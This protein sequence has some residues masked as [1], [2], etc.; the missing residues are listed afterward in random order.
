M[1]DCKIPDCHYTGSELDLALKLTI[2]IL[3]L[4]SFGMSIS[5]PTGPVIWTSAPGFRSPALSPQGQIFRSSNM[6]D[7][8]VEIRINVNQEGIWT[9]VA[10]SFTLNTS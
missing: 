10:D 5:L 3:A 2:I 4:G 8:Y 9:L 6:S 1:N 7:Y